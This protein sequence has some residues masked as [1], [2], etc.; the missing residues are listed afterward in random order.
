MVPRTILT[1]EDDPAIRR[2]IVDALTLAGYRVLQAAH[3]QE[4]MELAIQADYDLLLLDVVLPK[5]DGFSI[6]K[7]LRG[8]RPTQ[9][10]IVLTA[11]GSQNDCVEGLKL[12]ADDYI[13]KPF[14]LQELLA[15]IEAVLRRSP[16]RPI[17]IETCRRGPMEIDLAASE[18]RFDDG[19]RESLSQKE[20]ELLRYMMIHQ[21]R[22]IS[23]EELLANVWRIEPQGLQTRT[24]D[25]HVGRLRDKLRETADSSRWLCTVR[26][27]GYRWIAS[28]DGSS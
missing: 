21:N 3:G 16:A 10:V 13:V 28:P 26:G 14:R 5:V 25:V 11:L 19:T 4:G 27:R 6:L 15:R 8:L 20:V 22:V 18:I 9:P 23:R 12:G 24:V 1:V 2:G 17:D 7:E